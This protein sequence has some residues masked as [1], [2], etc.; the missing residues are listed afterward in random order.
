MFNTLESQSGT[1]MAFMPAVL[2]ELLATAPELREFEVYGFKIPPLLGGEVKA[3]NYEPTNL[4]THLSIMGQIF[5]QASGR[6]GGEPVDEVEVVA[7]S[8]N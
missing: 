3:D 6:S 5:E 4:L 8:N 7:P 2:N 1:Q